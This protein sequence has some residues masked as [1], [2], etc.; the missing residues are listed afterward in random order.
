VVRLFDLAAAFDHLREHA[1]LV[2][3][4]VAERGQAQRRKRV[5]KTRREAAQTAIAQSG[6]GLAL[7]H[8][9]QRPM[10]R[11]ERGAHF[12]VEFESLQRVAERPAH[13]ELHRH[14]VDATRVLRPPILVLGLHPAVGEFLAAGRRGGAQSRLCRA[15]VCAARQCAVECRAK[16]HAGAGV[17]GLGSGHGG[18][19]AHQVAVSGRRIDRE[20]AICVHGASAGA[21]H[22]AP[23]S[24]LAPRRI[25]YIVMAL[26]TGLCSGAIHGSGGQ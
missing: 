16:S 18:G 7:E 2:T 25:R 3:H 24:R 5:E 13:Q 11:L 4:A 15:R 23:D 20:H 6:V 8:L 17:A 21:D 10:G 12:S 1:V 19:V 26:A 14:V 22:A 9:G